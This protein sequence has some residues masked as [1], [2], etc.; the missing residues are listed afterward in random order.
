MAGLHQHPAAPLN[1]FYGFFSVRRLSSRCSHVG[2]LIPYRRI[3]EQLDEDSTH[4]RTRLK[5]ATLS[6]V[7]P[8]P[9]AEWRPITRFI[10]ETIY[11]IGDGGE[12]PRVVGKCCGPN[13]P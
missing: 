8:V 7:G 9:I 6:G 2:P 5:S 4:N 10:G 3:V 12:I 13:Q 11:R 1:L